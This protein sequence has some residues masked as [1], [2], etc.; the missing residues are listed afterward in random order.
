MA[1][2]RPK[3]APKSIV[4]EAIETPQKVFTVAPK[5]TSL[6][7]VEVGS[8]NCLLWFSSYFRVEVAVPSKFPMFRFFNEANNPSNPCEVRIPPLNDEF[9][10]FF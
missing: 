1:L 6:P 5:T 9:A 4:V 8:V 3:P 7:E 2:A 10:E